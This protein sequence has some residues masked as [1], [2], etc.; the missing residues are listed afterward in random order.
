MSNYK[1]NPAQ[2]LLDEIARIKRWVDQQAEKER[3]SK[4]QR[5]D[6]WDWVGG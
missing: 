6:K 2:Q 3:I 4:D 5:P 1:F